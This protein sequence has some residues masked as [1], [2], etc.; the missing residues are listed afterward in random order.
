MKQAGSFKLDL[1]QR[2]VSALTKTETSGVPCTFSVHIILNVLSS[3]VRVLVALFILD[4]V[5]LGQ[6]EKRKKKKKK[7]FLM[8]NDPSASPCKQ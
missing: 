4:R 5:T 8:L 6:F 7:L 3:V 2:S 1:G